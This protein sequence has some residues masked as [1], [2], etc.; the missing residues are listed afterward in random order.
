M[1]AIL[2]ILFWIITRGILLFRFG[3]I[4]GIGKVLYSLMRRKTDVVIFYHVWCVCDGRCQVNSVNDTLYQSIVHVKG[5][6]LLL[7]G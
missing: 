4:E 7:S 6:C 5:G 3:Q 1:L 2:L